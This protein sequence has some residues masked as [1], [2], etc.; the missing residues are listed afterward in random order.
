MRC[1]V[2]PLPNPSHEGRGYFSVFTLFLPP[3]T[4]SGEGKTAI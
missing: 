1:H 4:V 2:F 3:S